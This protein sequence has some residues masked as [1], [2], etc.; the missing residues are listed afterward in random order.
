MRIISS[1][2]L[3]TWLAFMHKWMS[4]VISGGLAVFL[5]WAFSHWAYDDPFITYRYA[6]NLRAGLGFVYN[7]GEH[8]LST[9]TPLFTLLLTLGS[10]L[11]SDMHRLAVLIGAISLAVGGLFLFD[12]AHSWKS[13]VAGWVSLVLYPT[14]PLV[15]STI[16]SETPLYLALCLG[17]FALYARRNFLGTA[18]MSALAILV[19]PDGMLVAVI[20]AI[21]FL[22]EIRRPIPWTAILTFMGILAAWI[23]FAFIYFGSPI[24]VT[25]AAKQSQGD[26]AISQR[27][28]EGFPAILQSYRSP[29]FILEA[30]LAIIGVGVIIWRNHRW[31]LLLAW[32]VAYFGAY[33]FLGVGRYFWYYAPLVPGFVA[34]VGHGISL[35]TQLTFYQDQSKGRFRWISG[36]LVFVLV[37]SLVVGN[38]KNLLEMRE[39]GD[40]RFLIY[41]A[42]GEW[43]DQYTQPL[44]KIGA[45]EVGIIGYYAHR[46]MVDFS[47]LIQPQVA[48]QLS[49]QSTYENAAIWA[50]KNIKPA[51]L[52]L[53][54]GFFPQLE[55]SYVR[56]ACT[57][58]MHFLGKNYNYPMNM[59]IYQCSS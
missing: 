44:D 32:S 30:I 37:T 26:M 17:S 14:F 2:R 15:V 1:N 29:L 21:D 56:K 35:P 28:L 27:F 3:S 40:N 8:V 46:P 48:Q 49:F 10:L 58:V 39:L 55:A 16:S 5:F 18:V 4:Y 59:T 52:V 24:P 54:D 50:V 42:V 45:L 6:N 38:L 34:L 43:L 41:Q 47:G 23:V 36:V 31:F 20:L 12:L 19:R 11:W 53:H 25:L 22:I 33:S 51:Y 57:S 13:P 7:P 9:T